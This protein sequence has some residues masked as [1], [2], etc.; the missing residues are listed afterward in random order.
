MSIGDAEGYSEPTIKE[1]VGHARRGVTQ[2][3]YIRRPDAA[4]I[5]AA[6]RVAAQ[7]MAAMDGGSGGAEILLLKRS[8]EGP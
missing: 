8:A 6:D 5:A 1:L 4:L 2:R 7:I 3:H